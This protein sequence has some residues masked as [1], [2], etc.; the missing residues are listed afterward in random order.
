[1]LRIFPKRL[2]GELARDLG[3]NENDRGEK[4]HLKQQAV[5]MKEYVW[6]KLGLI[7]IFAIL[8]TSGGGQRSINKCE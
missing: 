7:V 1:M 5:E 3:D 8:S 4:V 6:D 2:K